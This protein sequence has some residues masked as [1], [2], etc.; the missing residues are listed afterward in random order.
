MYRFIMSPTRRTSSVC[1]V[2]GSEFSEI[3]GS[4]G[5]MVDRGLLRSVFAHRSFTQPP[6]DSQ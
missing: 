1:V 2:S 3:S 4:L 6:P 5:S